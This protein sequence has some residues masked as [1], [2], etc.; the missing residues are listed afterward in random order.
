DALIEKKRRQIELL[1]EKRSALISH[2]VTKGLNPNAP[3]KDSAID[4]LGQIPEHWDAIRV[5]WVAKLESGHTP[6]KKVPEYWESCTIPWVSLND[7]GYLKE[8]DYI[9][10]TAYHVNELG[11]ANSSAR[12]L[13]SRAVL[14]TRDATIGLSAITTRPMAVSQ[15]IIAWLCGEQ[16][17]PEY[18]LRVFYAMGQE[19]ERLTMGS[20]IKT[21]GMPDVRELAIP[22]PPVPEQRD[23]VKHIEA[24]TNSIDTV[25][26]A[27]AKS[28]ELLRE[29][30]T[31]LISS[32]V[33]G[34]IDVRE[35]VAS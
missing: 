2:A 16:I 20:T 29:Y 21:I 10:D 17:L 27:V 13:P 7:T 26:S 3:M 34:K 28:V 30:R 19:L 14:F 31:A 11:L 9:S 18:L 32:A 33:T 35:E 5:M 25:S 15:H 4:W 1:Q 8:H 24:G 6:D 12:L 22:L 23:I